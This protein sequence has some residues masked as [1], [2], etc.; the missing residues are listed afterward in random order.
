MFQK[1]QSKWKVTGG[2]LLL[3][4]VTFAL[5]GSLCGYAGRKIL[6][7]ASLEKGFLWILLYILLITLLWPVCVLIIS[8]PLGQFSFFRQYLRRIFTRMSGG[9]MNKHPII[10]TAIFA[11]GAGSNAEKL[12]QYFKSTFPD[13]IRTAVIITNNPK[14]GV[15]NVAAKAGV[16]A[17]IIDLKNKSED[18]AAKAYFDILKNH[19]IDF[20]ILAGY[21]KKIPSALIKAYPEKIVNIHPAL[22]PAYGGAGMYGS[23]VH[24]AVVAAKEKESGITIHFVDEIYDHGKVIF[25]AKCILEESD[26]ADTLAKKIHALEHAHFGRVAGEVMLGK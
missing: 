16:P 13:R 17:E 21:L 12:I 6:Q 8:I 26:T 19:H 18:A 5:G 9:K 4:I 14:A 10:N 24:E 3:I 23:R 7:L 25:Q 20:I 1:L 22:L 2:R 15:L 11:S